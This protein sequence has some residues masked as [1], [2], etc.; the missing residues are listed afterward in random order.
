MVK[1]DIYLNALSVIFPMNSMSMGFGSAMGGKFKVQNRK[2]GRWPKRAVLLAPH[3]NEHLTALPFQKALAAELMKHGV[4][5]PTK[6]RKDMM[7]QLWAVR[8]SVG[9][10]ANGFEGDV[11]KMIFSLQDFSLRLEN[12][13]TAF[14]RMPEDTV[15][16]EIHAMNGDARDGSKFPVSEIYSFKRVS[17]TGFMLRQGLSDFEDAISSVTR[18]GCFGA[19]LSTYM[20]I[21]RE[22]V[23]E[24]IHAFFSK[25]SEMLGFD[26]RKTKRRI[27]KALEML[28]PHQERI[29]LLEVPGSPVILPESHRMYP[30]YFDERGYIIS[31]SNIEDGYA[32]RF[33]EPRG[34]TEKDVERI[35]NIFL[36]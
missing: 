7:E 12:L 19:D 22:M 15:A 29:W 20:D 24:K 35:S 31:S 5:V 13:R 25:V 3:T 8:A 4:K 27:H 23:R 26:L 10:N 21:Q 14:S 33:I 17:G 32:S 16:M 36:I 34:F 11:L 2:K 6:S 30:H 18:E 9:K 1:N 28:Q